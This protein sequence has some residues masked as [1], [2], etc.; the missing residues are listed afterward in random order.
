LVF[1][2]YDVADQLADVGMEAIHPKASKPLEIKGISL[3]IKNAFEPEHPV[4]FITE[5]F[6]SPTKRVELITVATNLL[7]LIFTILS[8]WRSRK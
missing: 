8:W 7:L 6:V 2:N 1:T 4:P 5:D 3:I